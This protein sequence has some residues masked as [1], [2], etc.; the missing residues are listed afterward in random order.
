MSQTVY[1]LVHIPTIRAS[2]SYTPTLIIVAASIAMS[3]LGVSESATSYR[4]EGV[5]CRCSEATVLCVA[6]DE[7]VSTSC[8]RDGVEELRAKAYPAVP[9]TAARPRGAVS[10]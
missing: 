1:V 4:I 8:P 2:P 5:A 3:C 7:T 6:L 10:T 9:K